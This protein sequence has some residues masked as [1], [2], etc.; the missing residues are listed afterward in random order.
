[1]K[2]MSRTKNS[3]DRHTARF[4]MDIGST[5]VKLALIGPG[6]QILDQEFHPRDFDAGI[7]SQVKGLLEAVGADIDMDEIRICS[8]ANGGLQVGIVCLSKEYSGSVVRNQVLLAGAN[9][10]FVDSLDEE[11][12]SQAK[13]DLLVVAGGIDCADADPLAKRLAR[14]DATKYRFASL[15]Y[16]GNRFTRRTVLERWPKA[17]IVDNP[18]AVSLTGRHRQSV[19]EAVR[20]A[21]LDDL[22]FKEGV[23]ELPERLR[24][25]IRPTPEVASRGFQQALANQSSI[26]VLGP[27]LLFDIGGATT[28]LHYTTELVRDDSLQRPLAGASVGRH[29]F[30]DLGIFAS[31]DSLVMQLRAHPR[32]YELLVILKPAEAQEIFRTMREDAGQPPPELLCYGCLFLALE[33]FAAG[34][35]P[36]L[37][38]ADLSRLAQVMLTGGAAQALDEQ[39]AMRM[40]RLVTGNSES[41]PAVTIDRKYAL[42]IEGILCSMRLAD[43]IPPPL[44]DDSLA[45]GGVGVGS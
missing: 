21:Y 1:M 14:F 35:G 26:T 11:P 6:G 8:S 27:C 5:V 43:G 9:P 23:S 36:G 28:D 38:T 33:R 2:A 20:R 13:V 7:A 32:L 40:V 41:P 4:A 22:I 10:K 25:G 19:F 15:L 45:P 31:R 39:V 3:P 18:L 16:A 37:P 29:V 34:N 24:R 44:P 42:W 12:P 17:I 30:T